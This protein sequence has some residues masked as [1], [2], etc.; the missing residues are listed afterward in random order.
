MLSALGS[1]DL[2][3]EEMQD[4][5]STLGNKLPT[6]LA[7]TLDGVYAEALKSHVQGEDSKLSL[8]HI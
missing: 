6:E 8:I 5:A 1:I 4:T 2:V 3:I 7:D